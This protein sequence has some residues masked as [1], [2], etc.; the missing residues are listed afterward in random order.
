ML[1]IT[2]KK[3][4]KSCHAKA[5]YYLY[6]QRSKIE[7]VFK[8]IKDVLGWEEFQVGDYQSIQ[9]LIA[10]GFFIGGYFYE[11]ESVLVENSVFKNIC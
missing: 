4:T 2:N 3:I 10:L 8:F 9:N 5:I 7:G 1:L 6:L 11:I